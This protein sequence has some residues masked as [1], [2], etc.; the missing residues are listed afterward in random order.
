[1]LEDTLAECLAPWGLTKAEY[2]VV[3]AL[4]SV[5]APYELRPTDLT[6][7]LL[8]TSGGVSNILNRLDHAGPA[9][10]AGDSADG[11]CSWV[12]LTG[13]GVEIVGAALRAWSQAQTNILRCDRAGGELRSAF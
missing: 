4:R 5:G 6:A 9:E 3:S 11:R 7:R 2:G 10:R 12:K 1:M 8:L 13:T